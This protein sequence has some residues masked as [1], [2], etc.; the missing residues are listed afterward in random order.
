VPA[1]AV[2]LASG[3]KVQA[4]REPQPSLVTRQLR[5]APSPVRI[6]EIV[7]AVAAVAAVAIAGLT[8]ARTVTAAVATAAAVALVAAL[9]VSHRRD[10]AELRALAERLEC[11]R[12]GDLTVPV[13]NYHSVPAQV[14]AAAT[15]GLLHRVRTVL[16]H[17]QQITQT[18]A[19]QWRQMNEVAWSMS[20]T[21][22]GTVKDVALAANS[23]GEVSER[24]GV[25]AQGAEETA[26]TIKDVADHASQASS[27]AAYGAEQANAATSTFEELQTAS[28]RVES[29]VKLIVSIASQTHL[30]ALNASIEAAR[31]G[32]HGKGFAVVASEVKQLAEATAHATDD[33]IATMRD[34]EEGS[35]RAAAAM[36][37]I[38]STIDQVNGSQ[39][40]IAAAVVQQTAITES[41]GSSS[42]AAAERAI[43][44]AEN[45]KSLTDAVRM[46][47]YAG[48]QAR[49]VA[50]NVANA[51]Q[52]LTSILDGFRYTPVEIERTD[53][54]IDVAAGTVKENGVTTVQNYVMGSGLNQWDYQG[55]WGHATANVEANGTNSHSS[56]PGDTATMRFVGTR[57]RFFGV[58]APNHGMAAVSLDGGPET[59]ID[60]Y[61]EERIHGILNWESPVLAHGE[62]TLRLRILGESNPR[63]RYVWVNVD[64][65]EIAD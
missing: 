25:I 12:D 30:L 19:D 8:A 3:A 49:T 16:T 23:A 24:I 32:E 47:A 54:T 15:E 38:T 39:S 65:A 36:T 45:V 64:R 4:N 28:K 56:M 17:N 62:H 52:A 14:M 13:G 43:A 48:A 42:A 57:I 50:A 60:Q 29:I 35:R 10:A 6:G 21:S 55:K 61:A 26:A 40:A 63:S 5:S 2:L 18:L 34:V 51:E 44:L 7:A 22:E 1:G 37:D 53:D 20:S 9:V 11:Y 41:I 27:V 59:V 46:T 31:A 33:V 58:A